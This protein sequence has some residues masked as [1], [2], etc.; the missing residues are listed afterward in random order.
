[1]P[2]LTTALILLTIVF[3][4]GGHKLIQNVSPTHLNRNRIYTSVLFGVGLTT[5]LENDQVVRQEKCT[6]MYPGIET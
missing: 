6:R 3:L 1:M 5:S 4:A 2:A